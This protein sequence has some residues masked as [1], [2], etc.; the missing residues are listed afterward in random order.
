MF[1]LREAL[2]DEVE[3]LLDVHTRLD[4]PEAVVL[5]RELEPMRPF[6]VEIRCAPR[7]RC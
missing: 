1:A 2:G 4:P 7:L 3:L 6:F 5:C